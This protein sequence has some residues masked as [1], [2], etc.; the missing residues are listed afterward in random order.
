MIPRLIA[1][2]LD[3]TLLDDAGKYDEQRFDQ[4]L[5]ALWERQIRVVI[6]T[7]DPLDYVQHLFA[8]L[9]QRQR[10]TYIV[11]DGALI[12][13]ASGHVLQSSAIPVMLWQAA[14]Q[15][16]QRTPQLR[17]GFIIACGRQRAYTTLLATTN[18]FQASQ[19][20]YPSLR[21]IKQFNQIKTPIL[22][23]DVT[24]T[25]SH[26]NVA[27]LVQHFN[28]QF[29]GQLQATDA[30]MGGM[31][32]TLPQVNKATALQSL[33]HRWQITPQ[34]MAAFGNDGND[35]TM[36][37]FVGQDFAVANANPIVRRQ[38]TWPL[39]RTNNQ[40]AV[41]TQIATWLV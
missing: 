17:N 31:N 5:A 40:A 23:L 26:T 14:I 37:T 36:L 39:S 8:P 21:T 30:G 16:I 28:D 4:Q 2:D 22:K 41:L 20:F 35:R 33:G 6:A 18:R 32:I 1:T 7:G 34:Q 25:D 9:K 3:G 13:T 19:Q 24:W 12:C 29:A 38:V 10:L 27:G 11:E 15:W